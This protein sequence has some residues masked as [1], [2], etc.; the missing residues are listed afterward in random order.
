MP[1]KEKVEMIEHNDGVEDEIKVSKSTL[2]EIL[3]RQTALEKDNA[4]LKAS[5][6]KSKQ[7]YE[8]G[9][10]EED[11]RPRA[12]LKVYNGVPIVAWRSHQ[13]SLE[14]SPLTGQIIGE[15]IQGVFKLANGEMTMPLSESIVT[16]LRELAWIQKKDEKIVREYEMLDGSTRQDTVWIAEWEDSK[17]QEEYGDIEIAVSYLNHQ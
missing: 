16:N 2:D 9:K 1:E 6:S 5:V 11:K 4:V 7:D 10:L 8:R 17:F 15:T 13:Q 14:K 12:F 3:A